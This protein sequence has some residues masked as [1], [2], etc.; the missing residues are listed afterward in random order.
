MVRSKNH[1]NLWAITT[2]QRAR[3]SAAIVAMAVAN[4]CMFGAPLIAK[5]AIDVVVA[6]DVS[7]GTPML[8]AP[9]RGSNTRS[10]RRRVRVVPVVVRT[11]RR[12]GHRARRPT[13]NT[14]AAAGRQSRRR[15]SC[16]GCAKAVSPPARSARGLL[17]R[18]RHRRPRAAL[19]FRRRNAAR[20]PV[21]RRRRDRPL[22]SA[23]ADGRRRSCSGSTRS[24]RG[25]RSCLIPF[26]ASLRTCSSQG[27]GGLPGHRRSGSGDDQ[28]CCRRT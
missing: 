23:G 6:K 28:P 19:Q 1:D 22:D 14:C 8:V 12:G 3:Y 25:C 5:Y 9:A 15:R 4:I 17:R 2:G 21:E 7:L 13:S 20:V 27:T 10:R 18:R 24:S 16:A 26:I 11:A